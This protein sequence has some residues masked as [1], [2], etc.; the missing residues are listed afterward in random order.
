MLDLDM[1]PQ[2]QH[3]TRNAAQT[4]GALPRRGPLAPAQADLGQGV[5]RQPVL[6]GG[7]GR[8]LA[9]P[10]AAAAAAG[11]ARQP[12]LRRRS[13]SARTSIDVGARLDHRVVA[14]RVQHQRGR[15]HHRSRPWTT[16][17]TTAAARS[18]RSASC[19]RCGPARRRC[20][21]SSTRS[22][23]RTTSTA[24]ATRCGSG[25]SRCCSTWPRSCCWSSGCRSSRSARTCCRSCSRSAWRHEITYWVDTFYYPALGRAARARAGHAVQARAAAQA[26]VAPGAARRDARDGR[27]PAVAASGCGSTSRGSPRPATPT[28]R[29][30][31]PIAFLLFAFFI[32]LAIVHRRVLQRG[33]PGDVAG[34]G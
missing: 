20:R 31:R 22:P 5:G 34:A 13:G 3:P 27:V 12:R 15:R 11:P 16:S 33:D 19:S 10:V 26:A 1:S 7:R 32:G 23:W 25:S 28:A 2:P 9:G 29:W 4:T 30:P 21:R 18:C 24:C 6:R 14:H 8:V 17:C